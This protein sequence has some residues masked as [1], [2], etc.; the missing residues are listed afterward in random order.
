MKVVIAPD[1]YKESATALEVATAIKKGWEKVRP[2]DELVLSPVSDGGEGL[3]DV[4][5]SVCDMHIYTTL[6]TN[7]NGQKI[8]ATYGILA[9]GKTAIIESASA[10]GLDLVPISERQPEYATSFGVGE[11]ILAA[12]E[13]DVE[14]IIIGL[15][16]SGTNDGGAGL[17][18]ALGVA[19]LDKNKTVLQPGGLHL[20]ELEHIDA[21]RL[22]PRLQNVTIKMAC[23]VANPLLGENGATYVFGPQKGLAANQLPKLEQAMSNYGQKIN[24][25][26]KK[27]ITDEKGAGAAGGISASL[28]AFLNAEAQSGADF[29]LKFSKLSEKLNDA[30]IV[31]IGEG[32]LDEQSMMGKIPVRVAQEAKKA[33]AFVIAI[34]GSIKLTNALARENGID[35]LFPI[36]SEITTLEKLFANTANRLESTALNIANLI[37]FNE[38]SIHER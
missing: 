20:E 35:A 27:K 10:I 18:Q 6:V 29:V 7:L 12:L 34:S 22:D 24:L 11:L 37:S 4:L 33:G 3:L 23:D 15:G 26:S 25:F 14:T 17:M 9:D 28:M 19:L 2:N 5:K 16:G 36:I 38:S 32:R 30:D 21:S 31:I 1:A 13:H 8:S